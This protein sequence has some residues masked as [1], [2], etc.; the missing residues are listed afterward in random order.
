MKPGST[1]VV[2]SS[3]MFYEHVVDIAV[4]LESMGLKAVIPYTA[5]QMQESGDYDVTNYKTWN[6]NGQDFDKKADLMRRHFAEIAAGDAVLVIN[7][8]KHGIT[9]YIGPNVLLEMGI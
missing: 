8:K 6:E 2:C 1:I 5:R 7:D 9:G 4:E 3:A